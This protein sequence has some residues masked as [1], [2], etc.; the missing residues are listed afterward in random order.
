[1][2]D[3]SCIYIAAR[4]TEAQHVE[5]VLTRTGSDYAV[6]VAPYAPRVLR[7]FPTYQGATFYVP[8]GQ[9]R[10]CREALHRAGLTK[11]LVE[12]D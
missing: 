11:G 12:E 4:Q 2:S 7:L 6:E 5:E 9:A 3:R 8:A 10:D 1:V